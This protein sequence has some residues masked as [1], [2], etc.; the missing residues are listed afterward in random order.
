MTK[1]RDHV[2]TSRNLINELAECY[3]TEL[4][5]RQQVALLEIDLEEVRELLR[6]LRFRN[7]LREENR[8]IRREVKPL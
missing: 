1:I 3:E 5:V 6:Q 8:G 7:R 4:S 2:A